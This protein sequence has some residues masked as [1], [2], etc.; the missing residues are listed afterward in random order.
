MVAVGILCYSAGWFRRASLLVIAGVITGGAVTVTHSG[1]CLAV[2]AIVG[3][4][5][6]GSGHFDRRR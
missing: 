5:C 2:I 4:L 3:T 1:S 6:F